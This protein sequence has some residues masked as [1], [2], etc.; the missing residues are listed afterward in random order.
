MR[1]L[2]LVSSKTS[3]EVL[4]VTPEQHFSRQTL[5][6]RW[7]T[8]TRTIDRLRQRGVLPWVDLSAGHGGRPI[9][10]FRL[11]DIES[12]EAKMRQNPDGTGG[13]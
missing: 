6:R 9:V 1:Y 4:N 3:R 2:C 13:R 10:R 7:N 5:A 11:Q 12:Y 8:S